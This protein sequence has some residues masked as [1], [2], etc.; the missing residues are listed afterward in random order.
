MWAEV[1]GIILQSLEV[2]GKGSS[3]PAPK[4]EVGHGG[5]GSNQRWENNEIEQVNLKCGPA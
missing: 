2:W 1:P 5:M 4:F 3:L